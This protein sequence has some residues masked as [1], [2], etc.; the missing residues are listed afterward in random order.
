[1]NIAIFLGTYP[2]N[3]YINDLPY[4]FENI[5]LDPFVL[6]NGTKFSSLLYADDLIILS[7]SK[8]CKTVSM[9]WP[10]TADRGC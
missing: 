6:P 10:S 1:M 7:R 8:D 3:L 2:L 4:S 9:L 5:L